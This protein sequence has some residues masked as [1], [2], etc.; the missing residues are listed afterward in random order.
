MKRLVYFVCIHLDTSVRA[1]PSGQKRSRNETSESDVSL[2]DQDTA[3]TPENSVQQSRAVPHKTFRSTTPHQSGREEEDNVESSSD[4]RPFTKNQDLSTEESDNS[5]IEMLSDS[6]RRKKQP[7]VNKAGPSQPKRATPSTPKFTQIK[8]KS[9]LEILPIELKVETVK[10]TTAELV[11]TLPSNRANHIKFFFRVRYWCEGQ[12]GSSALQREFDSTESGCLL[13]NLIPDTNYL[14]NIFIISDDEHHC[15]SSIISEFK[16]LEKDIRA[17]EE[18]KNRSEK[19]GKHHGLDLYAVPLTKTIKSGAKIDR[20]VF[21]KVGHSRR[22]EHKTILLMGVTGS[23]KTT[24]INAMINYVLNIQSDDPFRFQLIQKRPTKTNRIAIY[25]IYHDEEFKIPF[26]LTI[27]DTP[28]FVENKKKNK[29]IAEMIRE[30]IQDEEE[31]DIIDL[32]MIGL[33]ALASYPRLINSQIQIFDAVSNIF[34]DA[35]ADHTNFLLTFADGA[36]HLPPM[37]EFLSDH[38][39][40][41]PT[42]TISG[43]TYA[44]NKFHC[45]GLFDKIDEKSTAGKCNRNFWDMSVENFD[46]LF[47]LLDVMKPI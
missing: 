38:G 34:G 12:R 30:L 3:S 40:P 15:V 24:L 23:G 33:V 14:T 27:I 35:A 32:D 18:I 17:V 36:L 47:N 6:V 19:I 37:L 39:H 45:S 28:S 10:A 7:F 29:E 26:S 16:T 42:E 8:R 2:S 31:D 4:E 43:D 44:Y 13:E 22:R 41:R 20:F 9:L 46:K 21:G 5:S 25:D 1:R 11:W